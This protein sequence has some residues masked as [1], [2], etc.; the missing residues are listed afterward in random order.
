MQEAARGRLQFSAGRAD[1]QRGQGAKVQRALVG[2]GGGGGADAWSDRLERDGQAGV[3][4]LLR[5][6]PGPDDG[7]RTGP[8]NDQS[9]AQHLRT[10]GRPRSGA[11]VAVPDRGA[12]PGAA[13][14]AQQYG[15]GERASQRGPPTA[16]VRQGH[17]HDVG[18]A[19]SGARL[20]RIGAQHRFR[21][22]VLE[23]WRPE[24]AAIV[25]GSSR[26]HGR[27]QLASLGLEQRR[28]IL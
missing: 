25:V 24:F 2:G 17:S 12:G 3:A 1:R 18:A 27:R 21:G 9:G 23:P 22:A 4:Q 14:P 15:A 19:R 16:R 5:D 26:R 20:D 11:Q 8:T 28:V 6:D 7:M 13:A 10:R